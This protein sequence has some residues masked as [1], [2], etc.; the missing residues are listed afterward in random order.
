MIRHIGN[1]LIEIKWSKTGL[2]WYHVDAIRYHTYFAVQMM[3]LRDMKGL[4]IIIF[5]LSIVMGRVK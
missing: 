4:L 1:F 5:K 2:W 3:D